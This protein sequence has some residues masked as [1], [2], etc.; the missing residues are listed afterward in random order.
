[1]SGQVALSADEFACLNTITERIG[2][3]QMGPVG[4]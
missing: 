1:M 4:Q 2:D 3:P